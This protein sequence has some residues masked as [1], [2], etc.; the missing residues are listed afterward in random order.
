MKE[1]T[2]EFVEKFLDKY[3]TSDEYE[4]Y[5]DEE[6]ILKHFF[7]ER[8]TTNTD[9]YEILTKVT[10]L[11]DFYST[12]IMAPRYIARRIKK[13][14]ID[15]RLKDRDTKLVKEIAEFKFI[16]RTENNPDKIKTRV[17][18]SFATKY[19]HNSNPE[20]YPI[21]DRN[22]AYILKSYKKQDN[23]YKFNNSDLKNYKQFKN[24]IDEFKKY[25]RLENLSYRDLDHFLWIYGKEELEN[26]KKNKKSKKIIYFKDDTIN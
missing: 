9:F 15:K 11:N 20:A 13:L 1:I 26:A 10:L 25:Y 16:E 18:Y 4:H 12:N 22:V 17:F 6:K 21:Y 2:S 3:K 19:C 23:F 24:I 14:D 7:R 8:F 5:R